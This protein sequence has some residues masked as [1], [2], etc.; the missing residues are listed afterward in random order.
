RQAAAGGR[1]RAASGVLPRV[2]RKPGA[3]RGRARRRPRPRGPE[4]PHDPVRGG[5]DAPARAPRRAAPAARGGPLP[6]RA[7]DDDALAAADLRH[8]AAPAPRRAALRGGGLGGF[9]GMLRG[10]SRRLLPHSAEPSYSVQ[11]EAMAPMWRWS[12]PQQ[13][14]TTL[15]LG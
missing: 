6:R 10:A 12:V 2:R 3:I 11:A 7:R 8:R 9:G 14:P 5:C 15:R 4:L 13:P 1:G